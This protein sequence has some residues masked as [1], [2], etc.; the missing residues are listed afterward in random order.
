MI[1]LQV[2]FVKDRQTDGYTNNSK[3]ISCPQNFRCDRQGIK[4]PTG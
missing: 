3:T 4:I 1:G 2:M